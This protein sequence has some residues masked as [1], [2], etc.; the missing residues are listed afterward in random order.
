MK[1][2]SEITKKLYDTSKELKEAEAEFREKEEEKERMKSQR[3]ER[4]KEVED[5][6]K[7]ANDLLEAFIKDYGSFHK[8]YT[9]DSPFKS[10]FDLFF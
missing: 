1:F 9:E 8:T 6:Y 10:I 4:A 3:A 2:Y 5:A 7:K